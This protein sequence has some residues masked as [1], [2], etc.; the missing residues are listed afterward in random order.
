MLPPVCYIV[1]SFLQ[2]FMRWCGNT[3]PA[4]S[5]LIISYYRFFVKTFALDGMPIRGHFFVHLTFSVI[6]YMSEVTFETKKIL[7]KSRALCYTTVVVSK[8]LRR[9]Q[10]EFYVVFCCKKL[11]LED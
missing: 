4:V 3:A 6:R 1:K 11:F 9:I 8:K 2:S 5:F 10:L 7:D